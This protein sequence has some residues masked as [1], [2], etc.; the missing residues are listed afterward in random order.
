MKR[1]ILSIF[2]II[3]LAGEVAFADGPEVGKL[4][5]N[6]KAGKEKSWSSWF[7]EAEYS[8]TR[9]LGEFEKS[10]GSSQLGTVAVGKKFADNYMLFFKTGF[11]QTSEFEDELDANS[12]LPILFGY[13]YYFDLGSLKPFFTFTNGFNVIF[14]KYD[15][16]G[17]QNETTLFKYA[18][19]L[20]AGSYY[21]VT[22]NLALQ[23][24]V[25]YNSSFYYIDAQM[26]G[27]DYSGGIA[28]FMR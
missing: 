6:N 20:G 12:Y 24:S 7:A 23:G 11:G 2:A 5:M 15:N 27:F 18:W 17:D 3:L 26:T 1:I 8:Y 4:S 9:H 13:R 25:R 10:W 21:F 14:Q 22:R 16:F 28:F 19:Q